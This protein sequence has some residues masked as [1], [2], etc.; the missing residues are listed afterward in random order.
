MGVVFCIA[1]WLGAKL[2]WAAYL[3]LCLAVLGVYYSCNY[4]LNRRKDYWKLAVNR[5]PHDPRGIK[6]AKP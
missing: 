1:A 4:W 6:A 5:N 3:P 2:D